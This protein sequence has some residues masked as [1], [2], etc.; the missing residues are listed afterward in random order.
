MAAATFVSMTRLENKKIY[1]YTLATI[2]AGGNISN[3]EIEIPRKGHLRG[4]GIVTPTSTDLDLVLHQK[5]G[6]TVPS[7][8]VILAVENITTG[9]YKE[10]FDPAIPYFNNDTTVVS[11][12]YISVVNAD[13]GN[14]TGV[15]PIE[16]IVEHASYLQH[17][18]ESAALG[19]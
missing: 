4:F 11:K 1:R 7:L 15:M 6:V 2:I 19:S 16:L 3:V 17:G 13:G 12:L 5:T 18:N 10:L 14:P 8:D 9:Q